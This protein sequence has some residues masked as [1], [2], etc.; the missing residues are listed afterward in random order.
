MLSYDKIE[1]NLNVCMMVLFEVLTN[2]YKIQ[3]NII[4]VSAKKI[5]FQEKKT[6]NY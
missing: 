6:K 2:L 1:I 3:T 5:P 4:F